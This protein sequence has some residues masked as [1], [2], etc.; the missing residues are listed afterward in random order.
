MSEGKVIEPP[1]ACIES[2]T[3][4]GLHNCTVR[5]WRKEIK[6][7]DSYDNSD[8]VAFAEGYSSTNYSTS[9]LAEAI[10]RLPRV[11]AV[12]VLDIQGNGIV[13]YP[14]WP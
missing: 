3:K 1:F 4:I 12:E 7:L 2:M 13:I 5:V 14:E 11:S 6:V 9:D 8:V 10:A